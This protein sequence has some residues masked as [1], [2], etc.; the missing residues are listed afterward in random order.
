MAFI[1][2]NMIKMGIKKWDFLPLLLMLFIAI[3][4]YFENIAF[5]IIGFKENKS[6]YYKLFFYFFSLLPLLLLPFF[7]HWKNLVVHEKILLFALSAFFV[8][9]NYKVHLAFQLSVLFALATAFYFYRERKIYRPHTFYILLFVYVFINAVSL[10]W[11]SNLEV[12]VRLLNSLSPLVYVPLL[13]CFFRLDKKQFDLIALFVFRAMMFFA[14]YSICSWVVESRFLEY[15]LQA[16]LVL[17]KY[18]MNGIHP[19]EA[20][21]AWTNQVEPT[22]NALVLIF[23][24]AI[25]WCYVG[26]VG[27]GDRVSY[28]ELFFFMAVTLFL[29]MFT[30]SRLMLV[31]WALV[32]LLGMLHFVRNNR[33][34]FIAFS[35]LSFIFVLLFGSL[36][37]EKISNFIKDPIRDYIYDAAFES[38]RQNTWHGVGLGAMK[39]S[40]YADS[41]AR[42][43]SG[44]SSLEDFPHLHPHNQIVSDLMQTGVFGLAVI[45]SIIIFLFY[46]S[47]VQ[48]NW[49]L[50]TGLLVYFLVMSVETPLIHHKGIFFFALFFSFL[51]QRDFETK[52]IAGTRS[53][54]IQ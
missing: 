20:A 24:L 44:S 40:L 50:G 6:I 37:Y 28:F 51:V 42:V 21:Y 29:T 41:S 38:I 43:L 48:R 12:G 46:K 30:A 23:A 47:W 25:G 1:E 8:S 27:T 35:S 9:I 49:L 14:A 5:D 10:L 4:L 7:N 15:P 17:E 19:Y 18:M 54:S 32:N 39:E 3:V 2:G 36:F 31:V 16:G 11:T 52:P 22:Y 45:L 26:R 13:F 33:K 34:A 53:S